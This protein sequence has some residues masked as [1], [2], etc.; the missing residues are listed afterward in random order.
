MEN[1]NVK[2]KNCYKPVMEYKDIS[3]MVLMMQ[4]VVM[5]AKPKVMSLISKYMAYSYLWKEDRD[6]EVQHI[7]DSD[8]VITEIQAIWRRYGELEDE[9]TNIPYIHRAGPLE[10]HTDGELYK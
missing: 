10:V 9:I 7:I 4:T 6:H 5:Q 3:K 8:P 1:V 2:L